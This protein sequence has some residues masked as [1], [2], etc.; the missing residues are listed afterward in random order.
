V[1][2]GKLVRIPPSSGKKQIMSRLKTFKDLNDFKNPVVSQTLNR[3]NFRPRGI[4]K[5]NGG[6][7][8]SQVDL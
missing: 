1:K 3:M 4:M 5:S 6:M 2:D 7:F 8:S